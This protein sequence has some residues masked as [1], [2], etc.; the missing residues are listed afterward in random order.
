MP[1]STAGR[2]PR[3]EGTYSECCGV[4]N[5]G[6]AAIRFTPRRGIRKIMPGTSAELWIVVRT[7]MNCNH[8]TQKLVGF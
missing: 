3:R 4:R 1:N 6:D 8:A 7:P 2:S 5:A